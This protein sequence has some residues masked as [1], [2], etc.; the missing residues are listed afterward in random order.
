MV[1][2]STAPDQ[3][4][5]AQIIKEYGTAEL[6]INARRRF[7]TA[8]A[9][10]AGDYDNDGDVDLLIARGNVGPNLLYRNIGGLVFEDVASGAGIAYTKSANENYRHSGAMFADLDGDGDLDMFLAH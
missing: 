5:P 8:G 7:A 9:A 6:P 2:K 4:H 10:A 3:A 1:L